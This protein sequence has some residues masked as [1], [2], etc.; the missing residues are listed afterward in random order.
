MTS[1]V[2]RDSGTGSPQVENPKNPP[3]KSDCKTYALFGGVGQGLC[4]AY[5]KWRAE[6]RDAGPIGNA[7]ADLYD[8]ITN[9]AES[10]VKTA[11]NLALGLAEYTSC[12]PFMLLGALGVGLWATSVCISIRCS[13]DLLRIKLGLMTVDDEKKKKL[14]GI[15]DA[16]GTFSKWISIIG[17]V[18]LAVVGVVVWPYISWIVRPLLS[19]AWSLL[20]WLLK[21]V[22]A[23]WRYGWGAVSCL[24][25]AFFKLVDQTAEFTQ[26]KPGL[27][28]MN[29]V[30]ALSW[31]AEWLIAEGLGAE[32][33]YA[34]TPGYQVF[35]WLMT[36]YVWVYNGVYENFGQNAAFAFRILGFPLEM[37]GVVVSRILMKPILWFMN[38]TAPRVS[39]DDM[40][41]K[42][43]TMTS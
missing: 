37:L 4:M 9:T 6:G 29:V 31:A 33:Q 8:G 23:V 41:A 34:N 12:A 15:C 14:E 22:E 43:P 10:A 16:S 20:G 17:L 13:M 42:A 25:T 40:P 38:A 27:W 36:P 24:Y 18:A 2:R 28:Y 1:Y 19:F 21:P 3:S 7:G 32:T 11:G 26:S 35:F 39:T 5:H 30:T